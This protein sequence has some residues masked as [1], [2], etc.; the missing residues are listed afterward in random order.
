ME[1]F[2]KA[3]VVLSVLAIV[4]SFVALVVAHILALNHE[5]YLKSF[6]YQENIFIAILTL[7][8]AI[9]LLIPYMITE[10]QVKRRIKQAIEKYWKKDINQFIS[11]SERDYAHTSR[12]IAYILKQKKHYYWAMAWAGDSVVAYIRRF[13][14]QPD[15]FLI[16]KEYFALSLNIMRISFNEREE[17]T[18]LK[19]NIDLEYDDNPKK[20]SIFEKFNSKPNEEPYHKDINRR[21]YAGKPITKDEKEDM[22]VVK[23]LKRVILRYIKWQCIIYIEIQEHEKL[24][25]DV[26]SSIKRHLGPTFEKNFKDMVNNILH[27]FYNIDEKNANN[28]DKD[29]F[30]DDIVKKVNDIVDR[31]ELEKERRK[32]REY[33]EKMLA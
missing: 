27:S 21:I 14:E 3:L 12:M 18:F 1:K 20:K 11:K 10:G 33:L 16:N 4:G 23:E 19:D 5:E 29:Q 32:V 15:D 13:K 2:I 22:E 26:I 30:I 28:V 8:L 25:G 9:V 6:A 31:V 7:A 24:S 17:G